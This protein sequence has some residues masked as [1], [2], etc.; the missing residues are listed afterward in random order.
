MIVFIT[1][2]FKNKTM[3][4]IT[5]YTTSYPIEYIANRLY[6]EHAK[7]KS[8]YPDGMKKGYLVSDKLLEDYSHGDLFIFNSLFLVPKH[9]VWVVHISKTLK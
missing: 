6:G 4:N 3:E 5:I 9:I 8:I 1:G 7:I 2:C